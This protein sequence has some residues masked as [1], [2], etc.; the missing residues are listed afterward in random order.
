MKK[1]EKVPTTFF[2][3]YQLPSL[4]LNLTLQPLTKISDLVK[5]KVNSTNF[6]ILVNM[7]S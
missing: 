1:K 3:I 4:C 6:P 5:S 2:H 7:N